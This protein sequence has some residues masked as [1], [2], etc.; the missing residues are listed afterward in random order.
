MK[1]K[2]IKLLSAGIGAGALIAMGGL[3]GAF[4]D[5]SAAQP[6]PAPPVTMSPITTGETSKQCEIKAPPAE[7]T[8][9]APAMECAAPSSPT[10]SVATPAITGAPTA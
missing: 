3:G 7:A 2:Q 6:E 9:P 1:L 10:V 5:V 8:A 4:S